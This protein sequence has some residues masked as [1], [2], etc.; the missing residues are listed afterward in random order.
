MPTNGRIKP[1]PS[2]WKSRAVRRAAIGIP[3][4]MVAT[5]IVLI[6]LL[7]ILSP[8]RLPFLE[9]QIESRAQALAGLNLKI[10]GGIFFGLGNSLAFEIKQFTLQI[11]N[12]VPATRFGHFVLRLN[13]WKLLT[14]DIDGEIAMAEAHSGALT[15]DRAGAQIRSDEPIR[16]VGSARLG[17]LDGRLELRTASPEI[18]MRPEFTVPVDAVLNLAD[19]RLESNAKFVFKASQLASGNVA[20]KF[21]GKSVASLAPLVAKGNLPNVGPYLLVGSVDVTNDRVAI[22]DLNLTVGES[23][24]KGS[25]TVDASGERTRFD[26]V[27]SSK[28]LQ[29]KDFFSPSAFA[30]PRTGDRKTGSQGPPKKARWVGDFAFGDYA[31]K[32]AFLGDLDGKFVLSVADV[33]AGRDVLGSGKLKLV[34]TNGRLQMDPIRVRLPGGE[35]KMSLDIRESEKESVNAKWAAEIDKFD[36]GVLRRNFDAELPIDGTLSLKA[37]LEMRYWIAQSPWSGATGELDFIL[38]P[39][40]LAAGIVDLWAVNLLNAV[41][42]QLDPK[43]GGSR[44]NCVVGRLRLK[45]GFLRDDVLFLDT[46]RIVAGAQIAAD[47]KKRDV[48]VYAAPRAKE[49]QLFAANTPIVV[50]GKFDNFKIGPA[51][52]EV[53]A[54]I[55]RIITSPISYPFELAFSPR[56]NPNGEPECT[57]AFELPIEEL[58]KRARG[59]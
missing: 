4:A 5:P 23:N 8:L 34:L 32:L 28:L 15:I 12:S 40:E 6:G 48:E 56:L 11:P 14:G 27:L 9:P 17:K 57:Q 35:L 50:S 18:F 38:R 29:L 21:T 3:V 36:I 13:L 45:N 47:F 16:I 30:D 19:A 59:D 26:L 20:I 51:P 22:N 55:F 43:E 49:P 24:L 7:L 54:T 42:K 31:D 39:K 44:V 10:D 41:S 33:R 2:Y 25:M 37:G 1:A 53:L 58:R 46:T 52:G